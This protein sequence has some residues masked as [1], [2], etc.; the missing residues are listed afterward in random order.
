[1][2]DDL[3]VLIPAFNEESEIENVILGVKKF[4]IPLIIDDGSTYRT[5]SIANEAGAIVINHSKNYGYEKALETGFHYFENSGYEY[6]ITLDADS[7][8]DPE[9][10]GEFYRNLCNGSE[11]VIGV[12]DKLQR[13]AEYIFA[14]VSKSAWGIS[15][16]LCGMK[17][18]SKRCF[19]FKI[20]NQFDSIGT[21]Y[22][23]NAVNHGLEFT[24]IDIVTNDRSDMP[25]FGNG[26]AANLHILGALFK[27]L[28]CLK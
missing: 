17:A 22:A 6:L 13:T 10:I 15:D 2:F 23:I 20:Q 16:P 12:R 21:K 26:I 9:M 19:E 5:S 18:Y 28:F 7:Q 24:Q 4:A 25:R 27:V 8:H 3:V 14:Y 1:M 11:C